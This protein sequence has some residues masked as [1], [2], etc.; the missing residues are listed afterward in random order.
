VNMVLGPLVKVH[1]IRE[2]LE[3]ALAAFEHCCKSFHTTPWKNE[4]F[5]RLI[6]LEDA[7]RLQKVVDLSSEVHGEMNT[8]Y[9]LAFSFIEGGQ[10]RQARKIFET[11]GFRARH[12]RL[13]AICE[14]FLENNKI[15]EMEELVTITRDLFDVDRDRMYHHLIRAYAKSG[16]T[17]K[18]LGVWT[19][20]QEENVQPSDNT[21]AFLG[22]FLLRSGCQVPFVIPNEQTA[23][24]QNVSQL[25][26]LLRNADVEEALSLK[27]SYDG[28]GRPISIAQYSALIELLL[29]KERVNDAVS[30]AKEMLAKDVYPHNNVLRI[31]LHK[32]SDAGDIGTLTYLDDR[33]PENAKR[34]V[35]FN[36]FKS[37]AYVNGGRHLEFLETLEKGC[38]ENRSSV[39]TG[40]ILQLLNSH[41]DLIERVELLANR[42]AEND[43]HTPLNMIW[44]YHFIK[45]NYAKAEELYKSAPRFQETLLF[46]NIIKEARISKN[47][48]MMRKLLNVVT[49]SK[50]KPRP[51]GIAYSA[52]ID[53]L[54]AKGDLDT[55]VQTYEEGLSLGLS[56]SDFN[57]IALEGLKNNL[58][59][60]GRTVP[61]QISSQGNA[62]S[63]SSSDSDSS[64]D[65]HKGR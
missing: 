20:M 7:E 55:A 40:G 2:D 27:R 14:K 57:G 3:G 16:D 30:I 41:P 8:M 43:Y 61:F 37:E 65:E 42:Y 45:G 17:A 31:L 10:F 29:R 62:A 5:I 56:H 34:V 33:L 35:G 58:V 13:D 19:T 25:D 23:S 60:A 50:L 53:I 4:L 36:N 47:D 18:A 22:T 1:L 51:K 39:P 15:K 54:C 32:L 64:D 28:E 49:S 24:R 38:P 44:N 26:T 52:L 46:T 12:Q 48:E 9:D 63:S 6:K 21:L 59:K 11:P